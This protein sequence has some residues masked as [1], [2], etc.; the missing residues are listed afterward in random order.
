[1]STTTPLQVVTALRADPQLPPGTDERLTGY[2]IM[3]IP[4][5]SGHVLALRDMLASS[6]GPPYRAIWHRDPEGRWTIHTTTDPDCSCPRWFGA[7]TAVDRVDSI[8]VS[9]VDEST[10][11]VTL[12]DLLDW[13]VGLLSSPATRIMT[14]M[15]GAMPATAWTSNTVLASMGPMARAM[16]GVGRVR[17]RGRT[18]NGQW[19]KAAPLHVWRVGTSEATLG[20]EDLGGPA[21]LN[22]QTRLGDFW[23]PQRGIFFAGDARFNP[24]TPSADDE[25]S[26]DVEVAR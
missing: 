10:L 20:G 11:E 13:R 12:G 19:F 25:A 18:P 21:P 24:V 26:V 6:V 7:V 1:M 14:T 23:L 22:T 8:D 2:G 9:W 3:G 15:G 16:L 4:F 5:A 17:L